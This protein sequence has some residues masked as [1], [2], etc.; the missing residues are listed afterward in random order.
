MNKYTLWGFH[1]A[2]KGKDGLPYLIRLEI[3][4]LRD[5]RSEQNYRVKQG[6]WTLG[7]YSRDTN[8]NDTALKIELNNYL[9][10]LEA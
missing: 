2:Y 1:P 8:V 7:I 5:C 4:S 3:G 10:A 9:A 6:D